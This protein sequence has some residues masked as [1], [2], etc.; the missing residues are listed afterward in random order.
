MKLTNPEIMR[1][2]RH[3]IMP[4]VGVDGQEKLKAAKLLMIGAGGLGSPAG[5]YLAASGIGEITILDPD[6]VDVSNLQ[7]QILHDTSSVDVPKVESAKKRMAE[8][9]QNAR[10]NRQ[11]PQIVATLHSHGNQRKMN[12]NGNPILFNN[13]AT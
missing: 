7:R 5:L 12:A 6:V 3:L 2:G 11:N 10:A 9:A 1:Y 8:V 4:E 13:A